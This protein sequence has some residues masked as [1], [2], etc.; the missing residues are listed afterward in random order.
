MKLLSVLQIRKIPSTQE[1]SRHVSLNLEI[2]E[3][4]Q[5]CESKKTRSLFDARTKSSSN[6]EEEQIEVTSDL[7]SSN[8]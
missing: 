3:N 5:Q 1:N 2:Q 4:H 6:I 8:H 7:D